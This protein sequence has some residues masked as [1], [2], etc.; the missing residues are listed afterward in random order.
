MRNIAPARA[1][2]RRARQYLQIAIILV[3]IGFFLAALGLFLFVVQLVPGPNVPWWYQTLRTVLLIAGVLVALGGVAAGVRALTRK[4]END[5]A[6]V[7][8]NFL[9]QQLDAR[10]TFIR[11][12]N[13]PGLAYIDAVLV[14]PPGV[15]VFRILD[16]E[17]VFANEG[18][19][20]LERKP[21]GEWFPA[22]ISPTRE[23][24]EDIQLVREFLARKNLPEV[25]VYG[26]IVFTKDAPLVSI[27]AKEPVV[28]I[29][30][31]PSII[32]NL[33]NNYLAKERI[34]QEMVAAVSRAILD[35]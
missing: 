19:N 9:A 2:A 15:L 1:L 28:P 11:N 20:W 35:Q 12:I 14:G 23:V 10:Y 8:G 26:V 27:T 17:G 3:V 21:N 6:L 33:S 30:L 13:P 32:A 25:P 31:L 29:T 18:A 34:P 4:T 16:N 5:L 22:R 24:V 7:T